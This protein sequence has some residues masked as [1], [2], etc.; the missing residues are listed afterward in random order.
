[1]GNEQ[2]FILQCLQDFCKDQKTG[3]P[4]YD[5]DLDTV[6]TIALDQS[7]GGIVYYQ[8]SDWL[9]CTDT[10]KDFRRLLMQDMYYSENRK[11]LV[12]EA[13]NLLAANRIPAVYMKGSVVRDWYPV[14]ALRSM[15]DIDFIIH[16]EDRDIVDR[17]MTQELGYA[18]FVDNHAV[19]TYYIND[20]AF[21]VHDQMFYEHLTNTF[22][23]IGY[24]DN[25]WTHIRP[26][27]VFGQKSELIYI[28]EEDY[29]FLYLM[30]HL[31]KHVVNKG[32]GLRSYLDLVM[33]VQHFPELDWKKIE[34]ELDSIQLLSFTKTCFALCERWFDVN[35]PIGHELLDEDFYSEVTAKTFRDGTFGLTNKQNQAANSAKEIKRDNG[36]YLVSVLKL[37]IHKLFPSYRDMQLIPWYS[38]VDGRPWL[39]PAAWIYRWIYC[40]TH[41]FTHSVRKLFEPLIFRK[42][43]EA[44]E[45][46]IKDWG[47]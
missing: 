37:F 24:F 27:C 38:F 28:P 40:I 23:Y 33:F 44:R 17:I 9:S 30:T 7:I 47:L 36:N 35:M 25:I 5:L 14:P 45:R 26:G 32:S 42:K 16:T 46:L 34:H 4:A 2:R 21:E 31:A 11:A 41:K 19:W 22:D 15:G 43:I 8:C 6:Y 1:M 13:E 18:K 10:G 29:H 20:L 3:K 39:M 12:R